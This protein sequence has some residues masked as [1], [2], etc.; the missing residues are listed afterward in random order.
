MNKKRFLLLSLFCCSVMLFTPAC[1][2]DDDDVDP[3]I[4][5][6]PIK[7][8]MIEDYID[9]TVVPT[10][11]DMKNKVWALM[12]AVEAFCDEENGGTQAQL[13]AACEAWRN[14][15]R[16]WELSEGFL[17]GPATDFSLDPH[18]DSW[19]LN[20]VN[21]NAVLNSNVDLE[22]KVF[23]QDECGFHTIEFLIFTDGKP[24]TASTITERQKQYILAI[25]KALL[26]DTIR[27]WAEWKGTEG[28]SNKD[29]EWV[30]ER[31][32]VVSYENDGYANIMKNP[33]IYSSK[34]KTQN[35]VINAIIENGLMNIA[36]EVGDQ[37]IG[38]PYREQDVFAVESWYS[39]NSLDDYEDNIIS[40]ENS[41]LGGPEGSRKESSS[42]SA[43]VKSK[44]SALD[45]EVKEG[46]AAARKAIR[47]IPYPFRN[48]LDKAEEITNA[49]EVLSDL[50]KSLEKLKALFVD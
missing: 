14:A 37:K 6:D 9:I 16:P 17:Y 7:S 15:R 1:S 43:Y 44:N 30:E 24:K 33:N 25:T 8:A 11:T 39:W 35:A 31:E 26:D 13:D 22:E 18:L 46:I 50:N 28:I 34:Y 2:D 36:N 42:L 45:T 41:Y 23:A 38:N 40:I 20:S 32:L 3:E 4:E 12:D 21:I 27:L 49:M 19:P 48:N 29:S 5:K 47:D 10:Y